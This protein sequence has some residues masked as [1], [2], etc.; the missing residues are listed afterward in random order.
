MK[1]RTGFVSNSSSSSFCVMGT[2]IE[3]S[4]FESKLGTDR[5]EF[6]QDRFEA[7][8]KTVEFDEKTQQ[9]VPPNVSLDLM[10]KDDIVYLGNSIYSMKL[11]ETRRQFAERT[12]KDI[13]II[14]TKLGIDQ[15]KYVDL[16]IDDD[17]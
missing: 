2:E 15:I 10:V 13:N 7:F 16:Y 4:A 12:I 5:N 1:I 9:L 8:L 11:D 6:I 14:F 17:S 3:R